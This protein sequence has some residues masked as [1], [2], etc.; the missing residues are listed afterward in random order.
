MNVVTAIWGDFYGEAERYVRA[1]RAQVPGLVVLGR[2]VPLRD[3]GQYRGWWCKLE[4]FRPE[5]ADL[6]PCLFID[7]DTF[8]LGDLSPLLA[9]DPARLWLIKNFYQPEKSN[10]GL[11]VA[12]NTEL[13]DQIWGGSERLDTHTH[14]RG[15]GDGDYLAT[16]PHS[17]LTDEFDDI[18]SYKADQLYDDPR[19]SRVVCFHGRPKPHQAEGWAGDYFDRQSQ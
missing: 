16:F 18:R 19:D 11:F 13:S 12:P 3:P 6:R 9:V 15:M 2:D 1:L 5:N 7:L 14:G 17:R 8:I 4:V 10:S